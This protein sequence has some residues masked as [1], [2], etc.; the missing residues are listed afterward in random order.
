MRQVFASGLS[1]AF[2]GAS[3][4]GDFE[5]QVLHHINLGIQHLSSFFLW[6]DYGKARKTE[7]K[8]QSLDQR[9]SFIVFFEFNKKYNRTT[10]TVF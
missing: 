9:H 5:P 3:G 1:L 6:R 7:K 10:L 8:Y 4:D 2:M